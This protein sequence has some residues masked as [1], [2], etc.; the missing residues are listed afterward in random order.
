MAGLGPT[1]SWN[2][3][4]LQVGCASRSLRALIL[5]LVVP[6]QALQTVA[7]SALGMVVLSSL[8]TLSGVSNPQPVGCMQPRKAVNMAQHKTVN[9]LKT[10][11][12]LLSFH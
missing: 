7:C 6:G 11:F 1:Q 10:F 12:L 8:E 3:C 9:L 2:S 4:P 5:V